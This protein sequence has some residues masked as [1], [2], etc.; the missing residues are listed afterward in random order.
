[1]VLPKQVVEIYSSKRSL[2]DLGVPVQPLHPSRE[3]Q[4]DPSILQNHEGILAKER[5]DAP[6]ADMESNGS[7]EPSASDIICSIKPK[8]Q[9][10]F[11]ARKHPC[12][13]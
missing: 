11:S 13:T 6:V 1:M 9:T 2:D 4:A 8:F 10:L 5:K 12:C 7:V 3:I